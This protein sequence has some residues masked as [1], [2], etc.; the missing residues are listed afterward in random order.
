MFENV[1]RS[2]AKSRSDLR[3]LSSVQD[4]VELLG[5]PQV[6]LE[7]VLSPYD[8]HFSSLESRVKRLSRHLFSAMVLTELNEYQSA[9]ALTRVCM[10]HQVID[11]LAMLG[12]STVVAFSRPPQMTPEAIE[13]QFDADPRVLAFDPRG[14]AGYDLTL[15]RFTLRLP[16]GE[17]V[18][19]VSPYHDMLKY[20]D[21]YVHAASVPEIN[22][23]E[24][25]HEDGLAQTRAL[26][27][28]FRFPTMVT[29][30]V[31]DS[32]LAPPE[33]KH[34]L[35]HYSFLSRFT[36]GFN[37]DPPP[38]QHNYL[39]ELIWLYL[40]SLA[41][42][43]LDALRQFALGF[44]SDAPALAIWQTAADKARCAAQDLWYPGQAEHPYDRY[45]ANELAD[46]GADSPSHTPYY[47]DPLKRLMKMRQMIPVPGNPYRNGWKDHRSTF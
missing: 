22:Y 5:A 37:D 23:W 11:Q 18:C 39:C 15:G 9:L 27:G 35:V 1:D 40:S 43:E 7:G 13:Q 14:D 19:T 21:G 29:A 25:P 24:R 42:N 6:L 36:H 12:Q 10:E 33:D 28:H 38:N 17:E 3:L 34:L 41:A 46:P 47:R 44:G 26:S 20:Y 45:V 4:A 30:L 32:L 2:L 31:R 16:G 8:D